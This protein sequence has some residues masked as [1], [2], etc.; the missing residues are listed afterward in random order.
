MCAPQSQAPHPPAIIYACGKIV[1]MVEGVRML[2]SR[3]SP[4]L[5]RTGQERRHKNRCR[6]HPRTGLGAASSPEG[7]FGVGGNTP[8]I[9]PLAGER[10]RR[11]L[12][13]AGK[14]GCASCL[15]HFPEPRLDSFRVAD[16]SSEN[17]IVVTI[18]LFDSAILARIENMRLPR[19]AHQHWMA[20]A[21]R[22]GTVRVS[23]LL[24]LERRA[25][26]AGECPEALGR[27]S[28]ALR[29]LAH[30]LGL[31]RFHNCLRAQADAPT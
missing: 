31:A 11:L 29:P 6:R 16:T 3:R 22:G 21:P 28:I 7:N 10:S 9:M 15:V 18:A 17:R 14:R 8:T 20:E 27:R 4:G 23:L 5:A 19:A 30:F 25:Q 2:Q 24:R 26:F 13:T 1:H 12:D